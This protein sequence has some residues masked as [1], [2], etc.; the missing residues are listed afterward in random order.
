MRLIA[1]KELMQVHGDFLASERGLRAN[2]IAGLNQ[3]R[4][5]WRLYLAGHQRAEVDACEEHVSADVH[6]VSIAP[7]QTQI[8]ISL[9]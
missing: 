5:H 2:H 9:H 6:A 8:G 1:R 3:L 4:L 7:T